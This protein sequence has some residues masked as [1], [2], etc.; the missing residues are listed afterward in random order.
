[1]EEGSD[2]MVASSSCA[3]GPD[4]TCVTEIEPDINRLEGANPNPDLFNFCGKE[5]L[6][7]IGLG[8]VKCRNTESGSPEV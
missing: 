8:A 3:K 4:H 1:M 5:I 7:I 6:W 2:E